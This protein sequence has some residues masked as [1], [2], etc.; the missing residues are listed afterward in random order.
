M[1]GMGGMGEMRAPAT[2]WMPRRP[3]RSTPPG[4]GMLCAH[5]APVA[6]DAN[7]DA[8]PGRGGVH[9]R[10]FIMP[11]GL[12]GG[13][14]G[15]AKR[16]ARGERDGRCGDHRDLSDRFRIHLVSFPAGWIAVLPGR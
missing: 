13:S 1:R 14:I 3:A 9:Y 16:G 7:G 2:S 5:A 11:M 6:V 10:A 15:V 8:L 4:R 12:D